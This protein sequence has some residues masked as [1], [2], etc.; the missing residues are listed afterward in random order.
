MMVRSLS[1]VLVYSPI[2]RLARA[3]AGMT[4]IVASRHR[5]P[6]GLW[7]DWRHRHVVAAGSSS[8]CFK[9]TRPWGNRTVSS[10]APHVMRF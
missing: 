10:S 1:G 7:I 6:K 8:N 9:R 3:T 2:A 5:H 4:Q